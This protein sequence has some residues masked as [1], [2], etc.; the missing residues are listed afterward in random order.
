ML[1][2]QRPAIVPCAR[3][4][5]GLLALPPSRPRVTYNQ[6]SAVKHILSVDIVRTGLRSFGRLDRDLAGSLQTI[7]MSDTSAK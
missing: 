5:P 4:S 7:S 6:P 3:E 1:L 2:E